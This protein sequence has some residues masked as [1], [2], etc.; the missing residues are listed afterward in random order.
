MMCLLNK[1]HKKK[2]LK[3]TIKTIYFYSIT[4]MMY[5][6]TIYTHSICIQYTL[7]CITLYILVIYFKYITINVIKNF[8]LDL[9]KVIIF[10]N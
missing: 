9:Y 8:N 5:M 7:V 10:N 2:H 1:T 3:T 4:L 6:Y